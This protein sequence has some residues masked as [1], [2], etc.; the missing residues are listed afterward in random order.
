MALDFKNH[1]HFQRS[2][3][4]ISEFYSYTCVKNAKVFSQIIIDTI[5]TLGI[6]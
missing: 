2:I 5:D 6:S 3:H 1:K 4:G